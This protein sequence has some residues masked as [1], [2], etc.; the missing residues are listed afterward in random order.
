MQG[1][2][3]TTAW[4]GDS[5]AVLGRQRR[6]HRRGT[7]QRA[8]GTTSSG[9]PGWGGWEAVDLSVDHKPT[10]AAERQ[11]ILGASGRVERCV[12]LLPAPL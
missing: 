2:T 8:S 7:W 1:R 11:R 3:L 9:S 4:V 10:E 12:L 6:K 5:R